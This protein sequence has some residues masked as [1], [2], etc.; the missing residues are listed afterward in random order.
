MKKILLIICSFFVL[1]Y[2][3]A[4]ENE[5]LEIRKNEFGINA[6]TT[7]GVGLSYRFWPARIGFQLTALPIK[8]DKDVWVSGALT[9]LCKYYE[10]EYVRCFAYLGNHFI[11]DNKKY[12]SYD[13]LPYQNNNYYEAKSTYQYNIGLGTGF[14]FGKTV[15]YNIMIGYGAYDITGK[16]NLLP[17]G[18]MGLYYSF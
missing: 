17:A 1:Q 2:S 4:Q 12:R 9:F 13:P 3:F 14:G 8:V 16:F 18:E 5:K 7:T 6:G 10:A 15:K 11:Y